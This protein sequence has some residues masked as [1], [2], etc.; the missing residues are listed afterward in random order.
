MQDGRGASVVRGK[1][2][3]KAAGAEDCGGGARRRRSSVF[4]RED[5][6]N[7][8]VGEGGF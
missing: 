3:G 2:L 4:W 5:E 7:H 1:D 8:I 6:M